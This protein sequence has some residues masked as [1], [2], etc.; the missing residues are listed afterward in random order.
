MNDQV[1]ASP[2]PAGQTSPSG[3]FPTPMQAQPPITDPTN[4]HATLPQR[5]EG[6]ADRYWDAASGVK[7]KEL[8]EAANLHD[9]RAAAV[10]QTADAYE[11]ALPADFSLPEGWAID[12]S[13]PT[14][15]AGKDFAHK[16]GLSHD[17]FAGLA[18]IYVEAQ[19]GANQR[20]ETAIAGALQARDAALGPNGAA[21]VDALNTW[22]R[23]MAEP[24]VAAQLSKT[25]WT[26][27]IV[28]FF[29]KIQRDLTNQGTVGFRQDGR[30]A[31]RTDGQPASLRRASS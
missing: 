10:P 23:G 19:I 24:K 30:V 28:G 4:Q 6:L 5:P 31:S 12:T 13:D 1:Q 7:L 27:D 3:E 15:R 14:W 21:R 25:L 20:E 9:T 17:Q 16:A 11:T 18:K 8:V 29:E 22:F 26:P 2:A